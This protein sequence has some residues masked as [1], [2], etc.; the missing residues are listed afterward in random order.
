M[1]IMEVD[2]SNVLLPPLK[3]TS[4]VSKKKWKKMTKIF[5]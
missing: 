4:S 2:I 3:L 1:Y 5:W